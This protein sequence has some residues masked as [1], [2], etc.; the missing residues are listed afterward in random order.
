MAL[1]EPKPGAEPTSEAEV[2]EPLGQVATP[3]DDGSG[4]CPLCHHPK[5]R[6]FHRD[7]HRVYRRCEVCA[8]IFVPP[9][10]FLSPRDEK[11]EY[12]L[13]QN[14]LYDVG[15]RRFLGRL[16]QPLGDR[17]RPGSRGLDFGCGPGPALALM[18]REAGHG[19]SVYDP[20]YAPD[21]AAL[22]QAYDFVTAT[23]VFEH[24]HRPG[25][26]LERLWSCL[27]PGGWL[28]IM[29][30]LARDAD[31]FARWHYKED[32]THVCFFSRVTFAWLA[33]R[34]SAELIFVGQD[35]ILLRRPAEDHRRS[36]L[37]RHRK[38]GQRSG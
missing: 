1:R 3:S 31:A 36:T 2:L 23:E 9:E 18:F 38:R 8:L 17:L 14:D 5:S 30:K 19:M 37:R 32:L 24:L 6:P 20:F 13:H 27:R 16:F 29:T 35:V 28:G 33:G 22:S 21:T 25:H 11:A 7:R 10:C 26:E 34:W 15:Y 12:D 4:V